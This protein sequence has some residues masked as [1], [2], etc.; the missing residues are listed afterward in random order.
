M[1]KTKQQ[2]LEVI[3]NILKKR[4]ENV[5]FNERLYPRGNKTE[6]FSNTQLVLYIRK[7]LQDG[8]YYPPYQ[9]NRSLD[10]IAINVNDVKHTH[11]FIVTLLHEMVHAY[12]DRWKNLPTRG[13]HQGI[14]VE[15]GKQVG[16]CPPWSSQCS[17]EKILKEEYPW[18]QDIIDEIGE[19]PEEN[20]EVI[21]YTKLD[22]YVFAQ[23]KI[24][25]ALHQD[26]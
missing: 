24:D 8:L 19:L 21:P 15:V 17:L 9:Y 7:K 1:I 10:F 5:E 12:V 4:F 11:N 18:I 13:H 23:R 22:E 14:F 20:G 6:P 25:R 2:Y 26:R 16:L 3:F